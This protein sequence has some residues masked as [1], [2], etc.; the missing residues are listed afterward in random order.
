MPLT[1]PTKAF[2]LQPILLRV[3]VLQ[4]LFFGK[5]DSIYKVGTS[6][7]HKIH[8]HSNH[9]TVLEIT[10]DRLSTHKFGKN[11]PFEKLWILR[12]AA[13]T[14][15]EQ[16]SNVHHWENSLTIMFNVNSKIPDSISVLIWI[17][18]FIMQLNS[19]NNNVL[20]IP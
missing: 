12:Y 3:C 10:K 4:H 8:K 20:F 19:H 18:V 5:I 11:L 17:N 15:R 13:P 6:V 2:R 9:I 1:F 14:S 16:V 7:P